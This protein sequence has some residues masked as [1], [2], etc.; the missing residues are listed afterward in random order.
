MIKVFAVT[1]LTTTTAVVWLLVRRRKEKRQKVGQK[2]ARTWEKLMGDASLHLSLV[3]DVLAHIAVEGSLLLGLERPI[4]YGREFEVDPRHKISD[5]YACPTAV[6]PAPIERKFFETA[7]RASLAMMRVIRAADLPWL[8]QT[9]RDLAATDEWTRRMLDLAAIP[10]RLRCDVVRADYMFDSEKVVHI[11]TNTFAASLAGPGTAASRAHRR[12]LGKFCDPSSLPSND[13]AKGIADAMA[14]AV[15]LYETTYGVENTVVLF[16]TVAEEDNELCHRHLERRLF[17]TYGIRSLRRTIAQLAAER[18]ENG[19]LEVALVPDHDDVVEVSLAY[20]RL[21]AWERHVNGWDVRRDLAVKRCIEVPS[22]ASHLAGLKRAQVAWSKNPEGLLR[23]SRVD[24]DVIRNV[25]VPQFA[26]D[27][28]IDA[29]RCVDALTDDK[30]S[31]VAKAARDG[32]N[33]QAHVF[34]RK[35]IR[36]LASRAVHGDATA[37]GLV[38]QA[39]AR[40]RPR[41]SL[42]IG[43]ANDPIVR[44]SIPEL[45]IF[46]TAVNNHAPRIVG[47]LVRSKHVDTDDG[48]LCKGNAIVDSPLVFDDDDVHL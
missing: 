30:T 21:C 23:L 18:R 1:A 48:G 26:L 5:W 24:Q 16:V 4:D 2:L 41:P 8:Q 35:P 31:F 47:H 14:K 40:P 45:G 7:Q 44:P 13:A 28:P 42:V 17:D 43:P 32:L 29:Q 33:G 10:Q 15:T 22:A 11:E 6:L 19:P 12:V 39:L 9:F 3:D 27:D 34:D 37:K 25:A 20:F 36:D 46:V 38:V